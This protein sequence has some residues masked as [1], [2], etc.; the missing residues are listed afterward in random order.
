MRVN[1]IFEAALYVAD[2][3][4]MATF[5]RRLFGFGT[6]LESKRLVVLEVAGKNVFLPFRRGRLAQRPEG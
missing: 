6:L 4:A 3:A 5:Y 2:P 1:G